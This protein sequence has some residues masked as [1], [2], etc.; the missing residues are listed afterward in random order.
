MYVGASSMVSILPLV[1]PV[2]RFPDRQWSPGAIAKYEAA[3][4]DM[5]AAWTVEKAIA[6]GVQK[7]K[8]ESIWLDLKDEG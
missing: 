1:S 2:W 4:V 8:V 7:R 5:L 3:R 6:S